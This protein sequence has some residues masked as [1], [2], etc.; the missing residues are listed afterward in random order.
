[1]HMNTS[2]FCDG[3]RIAITG[4]LPGCFRQKAILA[5]KQAGG[6]YVQAV[7]G[8]TDIL[9]VGKLRRPSRKLQKAQKLIESGKALQQI[10]A[11]E[12]VRVLF[13]DRQAP[14]FS[15]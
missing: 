6:I 12:F 15:D 10:P 14:L 4:T 7:S 9:V 3:K 2:D 1:M 5:I 13:P 8:N 11:K